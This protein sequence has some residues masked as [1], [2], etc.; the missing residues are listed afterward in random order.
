MPIMRRYF[1]LGVIYAIVAIISM[2]AG[3]LCLVIGATIGGPK[4]LGWLLLCIIIILLAPNFL[5]I[6]VFRCPEYISDN[7]AFMF[8][9]QFVY[10]FFVIN[11]FRRLYLAIK[12]KRA[13]KVG[14]E[15]G[16]A[17]FTPP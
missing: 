16:K 9:A 17:G 6:W 15:Q 11:L 14:R 7:L 3:L 8:M 5:C 10:V 2:G 4:I 1:L 13:S 12:S